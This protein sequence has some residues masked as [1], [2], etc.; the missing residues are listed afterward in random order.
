[1][2]IGEVLRDVSFAEDND[3][4]V[5]DF[6][7][8][9]PTTVDSWRGDYGEAAIGFSAG[10]YVDTPCT[11]KQFREELESALRPG[12][13]F[14][15]WKG[16]SFRFTPHTP[17]HVDNRGCCTNTEIIRVEVQEYR[18]MLHTRRTDA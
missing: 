1:M 12:A 9:S 10:T 5:F 13:S 18:V 7:G 2:T 4:V 15:G 3:V 14:D 11:V 17:L 8:V 16:G 6:G